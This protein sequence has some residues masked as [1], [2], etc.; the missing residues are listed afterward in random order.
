VELQMDDG[1][2]AGWLHALPSLD[3]RDS[4]NSSTEAMSSPRVAG[5][6]L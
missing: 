2:D 6:S 3:R 5:L 4:Q 1:I